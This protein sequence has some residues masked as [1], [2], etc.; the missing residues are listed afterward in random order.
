[1]GSRG[2][3]GG[4]SGGGRGGSGGGRGG[5]GG[6]GPRGGG[7]RPGLIDYPRAGKTGIRRWLPSWRL[8]LGL[9]LTG[10]ALVIAAVAVAYAMTPIPDP[11]DFA[12][13]QTTTVY[14]SDGETEMGTFSVQNRVILPGDEIPQHVR[15]TAVAAEDRTFYENPG[16][17]PTGIVRAF[18]NNA[19]GG[20][21]QGGSSITQQYAERYYFGESDDNYWGK[22]Q[23]A[24]LAVKLS[25]QQDKPE[26]LANYL[27]TI[28]YGR[29][30]YGIETAAQA[31]FGISARDLT[32]AQSGVLMALLPSPNNWDP[33]SNQ[34][35]NEFRWNNL[36]D[37]MVI[38][39][40]M[41]QAERDEL[42][43][44]IDDVIEHQRSNRMAGPQG[45][46]LS[47]VEN[48]LS[49]ASSISSE[50][51]RQRGYRVVTTID[52]PMQDSLV[53]AVEDMPEDTPE[54]LRT[55]VVTLE[56]ESGAIRALYGGPDYLTIARNAVTQDIAQA[57]STFKSFTLVAFLEQ[58]HS[59]RSYYNG[60]TD[61]EFEGFENPVRN[62]GGGNFGNIDVVRATADSV[63]TVYVQMNEE[64]GPGATRDV[65]V[66]AGIP[67]DANGLDAYL[68]NTLGTASPHPLDMARAY[69][70][71]AAG[72]IRTDTHIVDFAETLDGNRVYEGAG[73]P[74]RVFEADIMADTTYALSQVVQAGSATRVREMGRPV[75][76]KTGT[77]NDN[78]SA[79]FVGYTP[80]LT[81]AVAMYQV[82]EQGNPEQI[83]PFGG[84]SQIT[85]G[86]MPATVWTNYMSAAMEGME[87]RQFPARADTGE[88]NTP[89]VVDVPSVAGM[90]EDEARQ[91][92]E[93]VGFSV[94]V[95]QD[96]HPD[97]PAG[98]VIGSNPSGQAQ[99]G[100]TVTIVVSTGPGVVQVPDVTGLPEGD[101]RARL[102]E[103][104]LSV[105]VNRQR[106]EDVQEG[107]VIS[108]MPGGQVEPG[109]TITL[110]VSDGPP[111]RQ[112]PPPQPEPPQPEPQPTEP[113]G[114]GDG[115]G[116]GNG[117]GGGGGGQ[118]S[119]AGQPGGG[120]GG[121]GGG[122]N[123]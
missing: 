57:G 121:G 88:P 79:W 1:G 6:G 7:A 81:T 59:L 47:L 16:I 108:A 122:G 110:L 72:G 113:P 39:G 103:A 20:S 43:Y 83:T 22:V 56:P 14:Y 99:I 87:V 44:P 74:E 48:E 13:V 50:Q 9:F 25:R 58:G 45:Y 75:A 120:W 31:Y 19:R 68:S 28:Y 46:L 4:G 84:H 5:S 27:N 37:G 26:I 90:T 69:N 63:N 21:R 60:N 51:L 54:N 38:I 40:A 30:A 67:E 41:T 64:V 61:M 17:N 32:T 73:T 36:M 10:L 107:R 98:I 24:L 95:S 82:G 71:F 66:R 77:S 62:F 117:G 97:V 29:D 78:F 8:I 18:I 109:S 76:G 52:K 33:H 114:D 123:P 89:P 105:R 23:E 100:S 115:D 11:D 80:Q 92:L 2:G 53:R 106:S 101:A 15:D 112:E 94:Q 49:S 85:G 34:K 12:E 91:A 102:E 86:S 96:D 70:T 116:E 118:E 119:G 35:Q 42:V 3:S 65:A 93:A 111:P 104:G 55:A